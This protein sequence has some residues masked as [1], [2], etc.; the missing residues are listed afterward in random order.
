M[1]LVFTGWLLGSGPAEAG[2]LDELKD[3]DLELIAE[4]VDIDFARGEAELQGNVRARVGSLKLEAG[5]VSLRYSGRDADSQVRW[6]KA[7]GG[8]TAR[9]DELRLDAPELVLDV[10]GRRA[11]LAGGVKIRRGKT[12]LRAK[13]ARVDLRT[14]RVRL[15]QVR[16]TVPLELLKQVG[17][18]AAPTTSPNP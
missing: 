2:P 18:E 6:V 7:H 8:V 9:L 5:R 12:W 14:K 1:V 13:R 11:E 16:G 3:E 17:V 10:V 15:E 4:R